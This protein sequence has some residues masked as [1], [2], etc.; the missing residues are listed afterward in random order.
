MHTRHKS[1][2]RTPAVC[3]NDSTDLTVSGTI[4][5]DLSRKTRRTVDIVIFFLFCTEKHKR[6]IRALFLLIGYRRISKR[7][8]CYWRWQLTIWNLRGSDSYRKQGNI[9]VTLSR[10]LWTDNCLQP[11]QSVWT[12]QIG[13]RIDYCLVCDQHNAYRGHSSKSVHMCV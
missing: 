10:G 5:H 8:T 12:G 2:G 1:Q 6:R 7:R 4:K 3:C 9:D 11:R 13:P